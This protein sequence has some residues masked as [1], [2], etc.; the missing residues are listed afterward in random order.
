[1]KAR[2][3]LIRLLSLTLVLV[4]LLGSSALAGWQNSGGKWWYSFNDGSYARNNW[5]EDG[6]E[7][8]YFGDDGYLVTG[9]KSG[10][11]GKSIF[12]PA[13]GSLKYSTL[14]DEET[15]GYYMSSSLDLD[16]PFNS[17]ANYFDYASVLATSLYRYI[18]V[19]VRPVRK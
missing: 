16:N 13:A 6:G 10:Y 19:P 3:W 7:W 8:Y 1:M 15:L 11:T 2:K 18:G 12:L 17:T 5:V 4:L 14:Q 9:K